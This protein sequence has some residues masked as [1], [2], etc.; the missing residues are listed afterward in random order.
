MNLLIGDR[1]QW[2]P[3]S[4]MLLEQN[5]IDRARNRGSL[6]LTTPTGAGGPIFVRP[7]VRRLSTDDN[8]IADFFDR[9]ADEIDRRVQSRRERLQSPFRRWLDYRLVR[10]LYRAQKA[11]KLRLPRIYWRHVGR[12]MLA[13]FNRQIDRWLFDP[14]GNPAIDRLCYELFAFVVLYLIAQLIRGWMQ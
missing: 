3:V 11:G 4:S 8:P 10:A 5:P 7:A 13:R 2:Y 1:N 6:K 9:I 12:R 14:E